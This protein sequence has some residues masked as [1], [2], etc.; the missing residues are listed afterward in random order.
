[1][2]QWAASSL[3]KS[4]TNNQEKRK[5]LDVEPNNNNNSSSSNYI[6]EEEEKPFEEVSSLPSQ[7]DTSKERPENEDPFNG[8]DFLPQ[9]RQESNTNLLRRG[10]GGSSNGFARHLD[11]DGGGSNSYT[12]S[13]KPI[14]FSVLYKR[15]LAKIQYWKEVDKECGKNEPR[16]IVALERIWGTHFRA[17]LST[18]VLLPL[19]LYIFYILW[20]Y[21]HSSSI[22]KNFDFKYVDASQRVIENVFIVDDVEQAMPI[23]IYNDEAVHSW[24]IK[25]SHEW[26]LT[27]EEVGQGFFS[28]DTF[29]STRNGNVSLE[30]LG[31]IME[32]YCAKEECKCIS[33]VHLGIPR[34]IILLWKDMRVTS[35]PN[36]Q[37]NDHVHPIFMIDPRVDGESSDTF[38]AKVS[39]LRC[40][41]EEEG[42]EGSE[43]YE[44]E[45]KK[46][47]DL[48][49][50]VMAEY[51]NVEAQKERIQLYYKDSACITIAIEISN[52]FRTVKK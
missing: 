29:F 11:K 22:G 9:T 46:Q 20:A 34:N 27:D 2:E 35:I 43:S 48:P 13:T 50:W 21:S 15:I 30:L 18:V 4:E 49:V 51:K 33:A 19:L 52:H 38:T 44:K 12:F 1:M 39:R 28:T 37:R 7:Q 14:P 17:L 36:Q 40:E 3:K 26:E 23:D 32:T 24:F 42:G 41:E 5:L 16:Y 25:Q 6:E 45:G 47:R 31:T 10:K 8:N